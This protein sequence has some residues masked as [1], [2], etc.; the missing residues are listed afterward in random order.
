MRY[1]A[2]DLGDRRTGIAVGDRVTG[3][4]SPVRVI[5]IPA[6]RGGGADLL[7]AVAREVAE[8]LGP[9]GM[10]G[11]GWSAAGE[12]V[13]GLPVHMDGTEG[14]RAKM[15]RAWGE[16]LAGRCGVVV[17]LQDERLSSAEAEW[18]L[19]GSGLT[20]GQK[21]RRRDALAAAAILRDYLAG[22]APAEGDAGTM[23]WS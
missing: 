18:E 13:L 12:V 22:L 2:V 21:K 9:P 1:V 14:P 5:E 20:R 11:A 3:I 6:D 16:R 10:V 7:E 15:V 4:V 19:A 17:R 8:H 23:D